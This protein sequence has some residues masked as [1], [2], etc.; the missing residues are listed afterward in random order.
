M[1]ETPKLNLKKRR[2]QIKF[3]NN[4]YLIYKTIAPD[5]L[6]E[7]DKI[8]IAVKRDMSSITFNDNGITFHNVIENES[9]QLINLEQNLVF[10]QLNGLSYVN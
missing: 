1:K 9:N 3:S 5:I 6:F 4:S 8:E 2:T 10:D 7:I